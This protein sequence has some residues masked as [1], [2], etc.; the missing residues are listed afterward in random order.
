MFVTGPA[1]PI[2]RRN[3]DLWAIPFA[4]G[5][6]VLMVL[7][8]VANGSSAGEVTLYGLFVAAYVLMPGWLFYSFFRAPDEDWLVALGMG[9]TLGHVIQLSAFILLK[10]CGASSLYPFFPVLLIPL[11]ALAFRRSRRAGTFGG[12]DPP[13][14]AHVALLFAVLV[15]A[16]GRVQ[17]V[18]DWRLA[19]HHD[20]AFHIGNA[21]ELK[22][23]WPLR[24]PRVAGQALNYHFFSYAFPAGMSQVTGMPVAPLMHRLAASALPM[25]LALQIFNAGRVCMGSA[26]AGFAAAA[27]IVLHADPAISVSE[28]LGFGWSSGFNSYLDVGIYDST[29]TALGLVLFTTLAITLHRWLTASGPDRRAVGLAAIL[30]FAASGAKGSVMPVVLAA[31]AGLVVCRLLVPPRRAGR[32]VTAMVLLTLASAPMTIHLALGPASYAQAMFR[33]V[34]VE[35]MLSSDFHRW[36]VELVR[37]GSAEHAAWLSALVL[38]FWL[39]GYLGVGGVTGLLFLLRERHR[40]DDGQRWLWLSFAGGL[41]P[42]LLLDADGLSQLFFVYN[43]QVALALLGGAWLASCR[44]PRS[45]GPLAVAIALSALA[46]PT[47]L[48]SGADIATRLRRDLASRPRESGL[49]ADYSRGL[50]WMR[51]STPR[52]SLFLTQHGFILVSAFAERRVF[53]E[54][55]DYTA[56]H[57]ASRWRKSEDGWKRGLRNERPRAVFPH[58]RALLRFLSRGTRGPRRSCAHSPPARARSTCWSTEW[59][60]WAGERSA[61]LSGCHG[62]QVSRPARCWRWSSATGRFASIASMTRIQLRRLSGRCQSRAVATDFQPTRSTKRTGGKAGARPPET[63]GSSPASRPPP[64]C[65]PPSC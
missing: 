20:L 45:L 34:P 28:H 40:L 30:A 65:P 26:V 15:L 31:L 39:V 50:R 10:L 52:D 32:T 44:K 47:L 22:N 14:L 24:D 17:V 11:A 57:H 12:L 5:V 42:A 49:A 56:A 46:L 3:R 37:S 6:L 25:L 9:W 58:G 53:Y 41:V 29:S 8:P 38:P 21:A 27:L 48:G 18:P 1:T 63:R 60:R 61:S 2:H 59:P 64:R 62:D 36:V 51:Q 43:G 35:A 23:H 16:M 4:L 19:A 7:R 54:T 13:A 33:P 55:E